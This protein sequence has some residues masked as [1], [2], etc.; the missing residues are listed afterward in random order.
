MDG[1]SLNLYTKYTPVSQRFEILQS[2]TEADYNC[3]NRLFS[4]SNIDH[5]IEVK[6]LNNGMSL[7]SWRPTV[8]SEVRNSRHVGPKEK[9]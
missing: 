7:S 4:A 1:S 5:F 6:P 3:E 8:Q 2:C 9:W